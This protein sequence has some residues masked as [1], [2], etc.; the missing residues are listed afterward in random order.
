VGAVMTKSAKVKSV[1]AEAANVFEVG[2]ISFF[3]LLIKKSA[4]R[5]ACGV[6]RP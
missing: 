1:A 4:A 6:S 3:F 2:V 5:D